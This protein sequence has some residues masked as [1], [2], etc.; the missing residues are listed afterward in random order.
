M[1]GQQPTPPTKGAAL[2]VDRTTLGI[3]GWGERASTEVRATGGWSSLKAGLEFSAGG[4]SDLGRGPAV[5]C[6]GRAP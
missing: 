3:Q 1:E 5:R 2:L 4:G 6:L